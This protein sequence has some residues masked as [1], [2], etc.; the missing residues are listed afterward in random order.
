MFWPQPWVALILGVTLYKNYLMASVSNLLFLFPYCNTEYMYSGHSMLKLHMANAS[1]GFTW[2]AIKIS[3][4]TKSKFGITSTLLKW[5]N[6]QDGLSTHK[7]YTGST[8]I[9]LTAIARRGSMTAT[10]CTI[11]NFILHA[12]WS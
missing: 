8:A 2:Q 7:N 5:S 6:S 4:Y 11:Y 12:R 3:Y 9:G 10:F 1:V